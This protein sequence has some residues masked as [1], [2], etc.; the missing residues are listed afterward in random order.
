MNLLITGAT[1]FLGAEVARQ[2]LR[3]GHAVRA[4]V[5]SASGAG[6]PPGVQDAVVADLADATG[7]TLS[8]AVAGVAGVIHCAGV[9]ATGA[10]DAALSQRVNVEGARRLYE[11]ARA[12]GAA[13]WVQISTMSAHPG[14]T[15]VYGRSKLAFDD[16]L[17]AA[18]PPPEA[19]ILRPSLIYGP[20]GRGLMD[21]TVRLMEKLP[22]VPVVGP[23]RELMRPV[24][25]GDVAWAALESL[26]RG[27]A[28]KTYMLGGADEVTV[29]E[30]MAALAGALG[31]RRPLIHLPLPLCL[32]LAKI[33]SKAVK[34]P[35]L[36]VD[37][38]LGV[39][40]AQRVDPGEAAA[41][42]GYRPLG[43]AAGLRRTFAGT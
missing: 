28:G 1:G 20:G 18:P 38:V 24:Y 19:V 21:K 30:F 13:R 10:T 37:N 42:F 7:E 11:A 2:A 26:E 6:L 33:L 36:T 15:S 40:Q 29:N 17:R 35:P 22:F 25:V 14:S 8:A 27:V 41:D 3:R 5:R 16:F 32:A 4:L 23:G 9:T 39:I 43:L 31:R 12:A 34:N